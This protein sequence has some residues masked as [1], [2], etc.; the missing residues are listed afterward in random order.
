MRSRLY[1]KTR[2]RPPI[3]IPVRSPAANTRLLKGPADLC[4]LDA[5]VWLNQPCTEH[6]ILSE[7]YN[8]TLSLLHFAD[9]DLKPEPLEKNIHNIADH[10]RNRTL[11]QSWL[12]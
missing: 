11:G 1:F 6:V 12:G 2:D 3:S 4:E 8:F 10:M 5:D 9:G 7:Q